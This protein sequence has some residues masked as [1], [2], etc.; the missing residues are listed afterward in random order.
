MN[1]FNTILGPPPLPPRPSLEPL[2]PA[3]FAFSAEET[4]PISMDRSTFSIQ[5]DLPADQSASSI[6]EEDL[7]AD[8][9]AT[10]IRER[11]PIYTVPIRDSYPSEVPGELK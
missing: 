5:E 1:F 10:S 3:Q 9:S 2:T 7:P 6:Q 11:P 8:Q 4:P